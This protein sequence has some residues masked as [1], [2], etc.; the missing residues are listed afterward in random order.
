LLIDKNFIKDIPFFNSLDDELIKKLANISKLKKFASGDVLFYEK[1]GINEISYLY[2]GSIKFYKVNKFDNEVFLYKILSNSMIFDISKFCDT[3]IFSCYTNA[4]FLEDSEVLVFDHIEF[5]KLMY[6]NNSLM[7]LVLNES[8][9]MIQR[10]QYVINRDIIFD[11]T[12][13]V[14]NILVNDLK[15]FNNSKK[16]EIA[17]MLNIQPETLSRILRKLAKN[18]IHVFVKP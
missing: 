8:F 12:A 2:K 7:N 15:N 17:Y 6:D 1:D 5:K 11:S 13:K 4:E 10:L 18:K 16:H 3:H 14:A 9:K